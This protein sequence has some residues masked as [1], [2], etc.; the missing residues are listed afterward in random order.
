MRHMATFTLQVEQPEIGRWLKDRLKVANVSTSE[1]TQLN[2]HQ[3]RIA[4]EIDGNDFKISIANDPRQKGGVILTI[5]PA[6]T[7]WRAICGKP[8]E[9]RNM[10]TLAV[11][12]A[13]SGTPEVENL[14]WWRQKQM[15]R[16]P[17]DRPL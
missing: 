17:S 4:A 12:E 2:K 5:E 14:Q 7:L 3:N 1:S 10:A 16:G 6:L 9:I 13:L 15:W 8:D 11:H